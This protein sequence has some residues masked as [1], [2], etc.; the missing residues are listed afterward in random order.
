MATGTYKF[1]DSSQI[2][3][4]DV[5][6]GIER[7]YETSKI[8][9]EVRK[10]IP[11]YSKINSTIFSFDAYQTQLLGSSSAT[12]SIFT[13]DSTNY[14]SQTV[15]WTIFED[16]ENGPSKNNWKSF[17]VTKKGTQTLSGET[18]LYDSG[19]KA[20][21]LASS[22]KH[23]YLAYCVTGVVMKKYAV[24]NTF[25][26]YNF[27]YPTYK[28]NLDA[29]YS[30]ST[31]E[32]AGGTVTGAG[33][34]DV[35]I[36]D[37]VKTIEAIPDAGYRFH[38]WSDGNT[39]AKRTITIS[40]N[41][42]SQQNTT[43]S[44]TAYFLKIVYDI[45][46]TVGEGGLT[47][48]GT[49]YYNYG[50]TVTLQAYPKDGYRF[51]QWSDG[52]TENPRSFTVTDNVTYT[53]IF[54]KITYSITVNTE[55]EGKVTGS[56]TYYHGEIGTLR[57]TPNVGCKFVQW[58]DNNT[59]NPRTI[60]VT[61]AKIYTAIFEPIYVTYDT[62]FNFPQWT[63]RT[64]KTT[65]GME[66][67]NITNT[68]FIGTALIDDAYTNE[69]RPV[70][71]VEQGKNYIFECD[72]DGGQ[73]EFFIFNCDSSGAWY[74]SSPQFTFIGG[75]QKIGSFTAA[76]NYITI[77]CDALPTGAVVN[78]NNFRIYPADYPYMSN[79]L[80]AAE[81][82]NASTW[83]MPTPT[84][85]GYIFNGWNTSP[86]GNGITYTSNSTYPTEDLVLYSQWKKS[87]SIYAGTKTIKE[88][89]I[90]TNKV[91]EVYIGTTKIY[92]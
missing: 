7:C 42:I 5:E 50:E 20:G 1:G 18:V 32:Y 19:N 29:K 25:I 60:T 79:T 41:D 78:Y 36:A 54:E 24:K 52:N 38:K 40:Q 23:K 11:K 57:A 61:E 46:A 45:S 71:P 65:S 63:R 16:L 68:G 87:S 75:S 83:N 55:T 44:L 47:V 6:V 10:N 31:T 73:F 76:T 82:V 30:G 80:A 84:R 58:S 34:W 12:V 53:A 90:G 8:N 72:A 66:L 92:G 48:G 86:D 62:I 4:G 37:Q 33:T 85:D 77:R 74:N 43:L 69:S 56:G 28:I 51:K 49:G 59:D 81:R 88:I 21:E 15:A 2:T 35:T 13:T 17:S 39:D 9:S 26:T 67:S 70:I 14:S 3:T 22:S 27:T 64:L 91:K 89:Y